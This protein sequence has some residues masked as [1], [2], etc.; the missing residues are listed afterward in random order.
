MVPNLSFWICDTSILQPKF[1]QHPQENH[2]SGR[3]RAQGASAGQAIHSRNARQNHLAYPQ[4][5]PYSNNQP[6]CGK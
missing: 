4:Q 1:Q 2:S 5:T 6:Q 3:D